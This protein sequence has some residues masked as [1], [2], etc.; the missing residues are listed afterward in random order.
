MP[1]QTAPTCST[2]CTSS[3][4]IHRLIATGS[5]SGLQ[6]PF[7]WSFWTSSRIGAYMTGV[8]PATL[9]L[10]TLPLR[11]IFMIFG[12]WEPTLSLVPKNVAISLFACRMCVFS[13]L[14]SRPAPE[15]NSPIVARSVSASSFDPLTP[16]IQSSAYRTYFTLMKPGEGRVEGIFRVALLIARISAMAATRSIPSRPATC[17]C[18]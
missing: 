11:S 5:P 16:T 14:S 6:N 9:F 1:L 3:R 18:R 17:F 4:N 8:H 13:K 2:I 15:R 12:D 7:A 10:N